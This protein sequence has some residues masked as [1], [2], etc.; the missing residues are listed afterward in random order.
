[1]PRNE[2]SPL[3]AVLEETKREAMIENLE[4]N[5]GNISRTAKALGIARSN[6]MRAVSRFKLTEYAAKMR[7]EN[8]AKRCETP[9]NRGKVLGR[10]PGT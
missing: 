3:G 7:E 9:G 6:A 10:Q 1:M 2:P 4:R 5:K 8:G